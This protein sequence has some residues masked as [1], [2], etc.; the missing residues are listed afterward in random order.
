MTLYPQ[1]G[2]DRAPYSSYSAVGLLPWYRHRVVDVPW[3]HL[4]VMTHGTHAGTVP[5]LLTVR[6]AATTVTNHD[7][8]NEQSVSLREGEPST[9][10]VAGDLL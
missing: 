4:R 8:S 2:Q 9:Q 5:P 7:P 3:H 10:G 1:S 6:V